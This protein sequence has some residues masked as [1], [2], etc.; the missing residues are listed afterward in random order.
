MMLLLYYHYN[1]ANSISD[2]FEQVS[3]Q[4]HAF[5]ESLALGL[6]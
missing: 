5:F 2:G 3:L 1:S 6:L 4:C